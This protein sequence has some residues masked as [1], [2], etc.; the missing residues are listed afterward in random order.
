VFG[1][2][3]GARRNEDVARL[4]EKG[5]SPMA[6]I[7]AVFRREPGSVE[8]IQ[9]L[10]VAPVNI[11]ADICGRGRKHP[12]SE[13]DIEEDAAD[14]QDSD[15]SAAKGP[16]QP[17]LTDL[18]PS[19]EP[20]AVSVVPSPQ[21]QAKMAEDAAR[22]K[23][24]KKKGRGSQ[25]SEQPAEKPATAKVASPQ[26]GPFLPLSAEPVT[27][28]AAGDA[29]DRVPSNQPLE[30]APL[31]SSI[32]QF[33]PPAPPSSAPAAAAPARRVVT[34]ASG[35]TVPPAAMPQQPAPQAGK[36]DALPRSVQAFAPDHPSV[37][38]PVLRT[39]PEDSEPPAELPATA[40]LPR[41]R[42]NL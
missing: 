41:P 17:L 10:A 11:Q 35:D 30:F 2:Y 22:V 19:M 32:A 3:S 39:M 34:A 27:T 21:A 38:A 15:S 25:N 40:P 23:G 4:L 20:I 33:A 31:R 13:S 16:K 5:F 8:S 18:P 14:N 6:S 9:N 7:T 28:Q 36:T 26:G 24:R 29:S 37:F 1:G 12:P 42:P